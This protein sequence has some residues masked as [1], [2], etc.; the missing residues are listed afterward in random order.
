MAVLH[1]SHGGVV[2][3]ALFDSLGDGVTLADERGRIVFSNKAAD[4]ILGVGGTDAPPQTWAEHY[5][6]FVP[7]GSREFPVE[8]YPLVR[9]MRGEDVTDVHMLIRN[10]AL[11]QGVL[12]SAT[13][14]PM[15]DETGRIYGASVV[16]RELARKD[17]PVS[18][19]RQ[20]LETLRRAVEQGEAST[21]LVRRIDAALKLCEKL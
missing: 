2:P 10:A 13:G 5:G 18:A 8:E 7:D 15:R 6:V 12:I 1:G 14:C 20:E 21:Q 4:R 3:L 17:A 16:F 11:P 19:L 9:A